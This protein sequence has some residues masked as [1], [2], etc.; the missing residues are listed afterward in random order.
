VF[1]TFF[2][3]FLQFGVNLAT[4]GENKGEQQQAAALRAAGSSNNNTK[5]N[6]E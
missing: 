6:S 1:L 2:S 5:L 3:L 4:E